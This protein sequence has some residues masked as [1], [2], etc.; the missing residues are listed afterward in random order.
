MLRL[1]S[2]LFVPFALMFAASQ[3]HAVTIFTA[4]LLGSNE[5]PP[6]N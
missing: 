2:L 1:R 4:T 5:N 6:N 3:A